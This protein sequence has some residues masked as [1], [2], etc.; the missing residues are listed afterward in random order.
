MGQTGEIFARIELG[1]GARTIVDILRERMD[2]VDRSVRRPSLKER[3]GLKGLGCCGPTWGLGPTTMSVRDDDELVE[4]EDGPP[5]IEVIS[6][7]QNPIPPCTAGMNLAAALAAERQLRAA[8]DSDNGGAVLSRSPSPASAR[9]EAV[10]GTPSRVSLMRLLEETDGCDGEM[11]R[12]E[13]DWGGCDSVCCVCMGRKKGAAFIPCGH[14]FCRVCSREVW[15]NRGC[16]PLCNRSIL[17]ILDI[18]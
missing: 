3:L 8:L 2:G 5:Q 4:E 9:N 7:P 12:E 6:V 17:E 13:E 1:R 18:Y 14:T 15:L 16:C 11:K 10:V